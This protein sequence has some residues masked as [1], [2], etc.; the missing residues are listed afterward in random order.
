M[1]DATQG[2]TE[3][4]ATLGNGDAARLPDLQ[5]AEGAADLSSVAG[6]H[7]AASARA[8]DPRQRHSLEAGRCVLRPWP[9]GRDLHRPR[10]RRTA[11]ASC[12]SATARPARV[13]LRAS[14]TS[15][16]VSAPAA[17]RTGSSSRTRSRSPA[18]ASTA[19]KK[20]SCP[21]SI[22]GGAE[23]ESRRQSARGRAR[24]G[25]EPRPARQPARFRDRDARHRGRDQSRPRPGR[26]TAACRRS[27]LT[28]LLEAGRESEIN[29]VQA[30][31]RRVS[32]AA[33]ARI[34]FRCESSRARSAMS[35]P[36]RR[37]S[38]SIRASSA[39]TWKNKFARRSA[40]AAMKRRSGDGLFALRE[41]PFR[42]ARIRDAH[43]RL[44]AKRRRR[45]LVQG[46]R[47]RRC[48]RPATIRRRWLCRPSR[49]PLNAVVTCGDA[50]VLQVYPAHLKLTAAAPPP[51]D[52]CEP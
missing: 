35:I 50:E 27:S 22:S 6:R 8:G 34:A 43:R 31:D 2:K 36:G 25:S 37:N 14:T 45:A 1:T 11:T 12:S 4:E 5:A 33:A 30:H 23:P 49:K 40:W 18:A 44:R 41:P 29:A 13:C 28:V 47:A 9:E 7:A 19:W 20:Y 52:P 32:T 26:W 17:A 39:R 46:H 21:A 10:R 3:R 42:R 16:R 38:L 15:R 51:T 48:S 24:E